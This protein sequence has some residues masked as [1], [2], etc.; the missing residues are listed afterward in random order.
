MGFLSIFNI[1]EAKSL[2]TDVE[3]CRTCPYIENIALNGRFTT[4][5]GTHTLYSIDIRKCIPK[6]LKKV[7]AYEVIYDPATRKCYCATPDCGKFK[8]LING[9]RVEFDTSSIVAMSGVLAGKIELVLAE[10]Y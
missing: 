7:G 6:G 8:L 5:D 10:T 2:L 9:E 3:F 4:M 1:G